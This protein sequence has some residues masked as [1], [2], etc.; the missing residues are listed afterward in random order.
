MIAASLKRVTLTF[1]AEG[2]HHFRDH[3]I[4][5]SLKPGRAV[6]VPVPVSGFP[7]S[8]DR[9]LIEAGTC[10]RRKPRAA[11]F[12]RSYDRGLIEAR[13]RQERRAYCPHFRDH[14]I[15]ASLKL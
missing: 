2:A 15:A 14:M 5:A 7:R 8:Y 11:S 10:S 13:N 6:A 12:P 1:G 9:G 3:M 4:A